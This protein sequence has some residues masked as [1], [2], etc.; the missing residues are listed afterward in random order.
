MTYPINETFDTAPPVGF[1]SLYKSD[2]YP[3]TATH[4]ASAQAIDLQSGA[5]QSL[6]RIDAAGA[7]TAFSFTADLEL[8]ADTAGGYHM[9]LWLTNT[10]G[11]AGD[12]GLR[13][14]NSKLSGTW[15]SSVWVGAISTGANYELTRQIVGVQPYSDVGSRVLLRVEYRPCLYAKN[16]SNVYF[17]MDDVLV[18][19]IPNVKTIPMYAGVLLY[20]TS[21]RV[22]SIGL[23]DP[24]TELL[25]ELQASTDQEPLYK[26][27]NPTQPPA[28]ITMSAPQKVNSNSLVKNYRSFTRWQSELS[29][30]AAN[31]G[32]VI[33]SGVVTIQGTAAAR[34]VRLYNKSTGQL[35][36]QVM[37]G[38][39]GSYTFT[40]LDPSFEYFAVAHD[41]TRTYN[42]VIQDMIQP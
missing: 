16:F 5:Q 3:F 33:V 18:A 30:F 32:G 19:W 36:G 37:S 8:L 7:L 34:K 29:P 28:Q 41:H 6:W 4:N 40:N 21:V 23:N 20:G 9:G 38:I 2:I 13:Y 14:T 27:T 1:W 31:Y 39:N 15:F 26:Y 35:V 11:G 17:F 42:A 22:H 10:L 25:P 12:Y 24:T